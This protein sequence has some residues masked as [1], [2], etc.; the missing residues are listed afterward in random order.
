MQTPVLAFIHNH[1]F[2]TNIEPLDR[3]YGSRFSRIRH[4]MPFYR[5]SSAHVHRVYESSHQFHGFVAQACERLMHDDAEHYVF[6]G[7]DLLLNP[8]F[9]EANLA[10][11][12]SL[13]A[14]SAYIKGMN[15]LATFRFRWPHKAGALLAFVQNTGVEWARELPDRAEAIRCFARHG[16]SVGQ[17]RWGDLR[18]GIGP[19]QI[20]QAIFYVLKRLQSAGRVGGLGEMPYPLVNSYA[21][22]FVVPRQSLERFA[23]LCGIFAAMNLFAE[24]AIPTALLLTCDRVVEERPDGNR[25]VELW[26]KSE[27]SGLEQKFGGDLSALLSSF[28]PEQLY[29]HPVKLSRWKN[30]PGA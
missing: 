3:L 20:F 5:G 18:Y 25:G 13:D 24:V 15:D 26:T 2:E 7:D 11:E 1:R 8:R 14:G 23:H 28:P 29:V 21:D 6:C 22:F 19:R 12:L 27:I 16:V 10:A 4:L 9:N 30:A 17:I